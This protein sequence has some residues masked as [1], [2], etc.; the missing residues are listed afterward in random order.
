MSKLKTK[1]LICQLSDLETSLNGFSFE[2]LS[3]L[4]AK[5]LKNSFNRFKT[6]L[7]DQIFGT[8][9]INE[10]DFFTNEIISVPTPSQ[11]NKLIAHVSHEIRTPLNGIIGFTNLLR[12]ENLTEGQFKKVEAIQS[13]S[14]NLMEIIKEVLEYS[15]LTAGI[16][17]FDSVDFNLHRLLKDVMFL[18]QTLIVDKSVTLNIDISPDVPNILI[19]DP[20]KLS[21][22]LLN[23]LGNAIKFVEKGQISLSV[24]VTEQKKGTHMLQFSVK[25]TGIGISKEQLGHIFES[26]KQ[27][28]KDTFQKYGGS[29]LGLSIVKE[30]IEKQG[31]SIAV[32]SI[33]GAG[34]TFKFLIPF[35]K[36]NIQNISKNKPKS[37]ST[38][39]G[40]ELLGGTK[41]LVFED[42]ELNQ[43]LISEQLTKWNCI[44]HV[45]ANPKEGLSLLNTE[46]IDIV[47]MDLKM[48]K[49]SGFEISK[50][51]RS[52]QDTTLNQVPIIAFS[53]DFTAQDQEYCYESGINDFLLKP[54]TLNEL[55]I[56]LLKRKKERNLTQASLRLLK[57]ETIISIKQKKETV[58]LSS[59]LQE[60][61]DEIEMLEELV[62]LFKQNIYEFIGAVKIAISNKN[63]EEIYHASHKIK[64]GLAL[65]N[66]N[67]LKRLIVGMEDGAKNTELAKIELL[68]AQFLVQY[69][70]KEAQIDKELKKLKKR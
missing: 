24:V 53:A 41:I 26:Y 39:K 61:D 65:M 64:A 25:D 68:F 49:M 2:E 42:N 54:Y 21:Q 36:G 10:K 11:D 55:M 45:T 28:E 9:K 20:S 7:N 8:D 43:H 62:R 1:D 31:G 44:T 37:I 57:Q 16:E 56:K 18:C 50:S 6:Q 19:G 32:T 35:R 63:F 38:Q 5:T 23:L 51:I 34:T 48:P 22:I 59:L 67:D 70:L 46:E 4:E 17:D 30:I 47:L 33:L 58:E 69:P 40:K 29:G 3:T 13:A 15:K 27:A 14:Y 60:C 66:T 52:L 12:E